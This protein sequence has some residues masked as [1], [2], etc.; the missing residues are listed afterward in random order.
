VDSER[1]LGKLLRKLDSINKFNAC[2]WF[3]IF[4]T[5]QAAL[6]LVLDINCRVKQ[7]CSESST[8]SQTLLRDLASLIG[9]H[10]RDPRVPGS[11]QKWASVIIDVSSTSDQFTAAYQLQSITAPIKELSPMSTQPATV[12]VHSLSHTLADTQASSSRYDAAGQ[13][14]PFSPEDFNLIKENNQEFWAQLSFGDDAND[15][16]QDW[17]WDDIES[18][19]RNSSTQPP[20]PENRRRLL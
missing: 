17:S 14:E 16:L 10:L 18:I 2:T 19:L 15:P 3:D 20:V 6:V 8:G 7:Q 1:S 5:V 4:Y 12:D 9:R 13:N 11:M